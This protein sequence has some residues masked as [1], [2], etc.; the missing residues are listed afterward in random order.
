MEEGRR[1]K[2]SVALHA[3]SQGR[4]P[5]ISFCF[6]CFLRNNQR[7]HLMKRSEDATINGK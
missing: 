6:G 4:K 2:G 1:K 5:I 7:P 3:T